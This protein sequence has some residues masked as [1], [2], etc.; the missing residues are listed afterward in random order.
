MEEI[1]FQSWKSLKI[2]LVLFFDFAEEVIEGQR[3]EYL[4]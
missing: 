2:L 4:V 1:E 3:R